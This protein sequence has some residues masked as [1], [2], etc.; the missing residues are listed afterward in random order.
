MRLS[1]LTSA[2]AIAVVAGAVA[3]APAT[4]AFASV[5]THNPADVGLFGAGDPTFD[6]AFRQSLGLLAEQAAGVHDTAAI[7]W[8]VNQQCPD[9]GWAAYRADLSKPC[10]ATDLS[11]FTGEDSNSTAIAIQALHALGV[12][13]KHDA[14]VF[15]H[16]LQDSDGGFPLIAGSGTDPNSTGLVV[17]AIKA[18][19]QDPAGA[20]WTVSGHTPLDALMASWVN[21]PSSGTDP[22][23]GAFGSPFSSG[24]GDLIAT[25]QAVWG[26]EQRAFPITGSA[27]TAQPA[28][29]CSGG[30]VSPTPAQAGQFAATWLAG[31]LTGGFLTTGSSPDYSLT[32]QGVLAMAASGTNANGMSTALDHLAAHVQSAV[33]DSHSNVSPGSVGYIAL[34]AHAAGRSETS[35]GGRNLI[36]TLQSVRR[37]LPVAAPVKKPVTHPVTQPAHQPSTTSGGGTSSSPATL[38]VTGS[39]AVDH[40][41]VGVGLLLAGALLLFA[42]RRRNPA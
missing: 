21:C 33:L 25:V 27:T 19:G 31:K 14:I 36:T 29:D 16:S 26:V 13:P 5:T 28:P 11:S 12:T 39:R 42:G 3:L 22:D 17:Q 15:L 40:S 2:A 9:G 6:G 23:A 30:P 4:A 20:A 34:A 41:L 38:P 18:V 8:L 24:H 32:A 1:K 10:P 7:T 35:F 37:A